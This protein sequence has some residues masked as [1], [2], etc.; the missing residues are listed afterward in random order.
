MKVLDF[1]LAKALDPAAS[2]SPEAM[3]SPTISVRGTQMG[4]IIGTAA[5]MAPEQAR[6]KIVDRRAD[7]WAFGVVLYEMLSGR[8]AFDGEDVSTILASVIKERGELAG[9]PRGSPRTHPAS[10]APLPGEGSRRRLRDI[11]EARLTL[12]DPTS[13]EPKANARPPATSAISAPASLWRRALP[14]AATA[15]VAGV[16][17]KHP[18]VE[19][20]AGNGDSRYGGDAVSDRASRRTGGHAA[21]CCG[22]RFF[23]RRR[24]ARIRREP[25]AVPPVDGRCRSEADSGQQCRRRE[26]VFLARR[27]MGGIFFVRR[28]SAAKDPDRRRLAGD[29]VQNRRRR[30]APP[31]TAIRSSSPVG[32]TGSCAC[33]RTV[34]SPRSW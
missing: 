25:P 17:R 21:E 7:I 14:I 13:S 31:G 19:L 8:R 16:D 28:F 10:A 4:L 12:E 29:F 1:G 33:P 24:P 26:P 3:N 34:V 20:S 30:G 27:T 32:P 11:G 22:G 2:S 23:A 5:Y 6:G 15:L 18:D 9:A